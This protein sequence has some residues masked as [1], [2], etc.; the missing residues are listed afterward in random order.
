MRE[1][2]NAS[3]GDKFQIITRHDSAQLVIPKSYLGAEYSEAIIFIQIT[4]SF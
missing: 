4:I 3:E 1:Q 2:I